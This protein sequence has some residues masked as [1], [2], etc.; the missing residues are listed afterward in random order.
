MTIRDAIQ[1]D[2]EDIQSASTLQQLEMVAAT[3]VAGGVLLRTAIA[4]VIFARETGEEP[5][6]P[7]YLV[8]SPALAD[9][10]RPVDK[11]ARSFSTVFAMGLAV[12]VGAGW[13]FSQPVVAV[14]ALL[15]WLA[16]ALDPFLGAVYWRFNNA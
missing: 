5:S 7:T 8:V 2:L 12:T 15:N 3:V 1:D 9:T 4:A 13:S 10:P 6:E 14:V 11:I 16:L